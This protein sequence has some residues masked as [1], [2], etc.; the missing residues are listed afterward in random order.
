M[1][2][3]AESRAFPTSKVHL[4]F[5]RS[6]SKTSEDAVNTLKT[7]LRCR[8]SPAL[9]ATL[10]GDA[11]KDGYDECFTTLDLFA[12]DLT[13]GEASFIKCGA[14]DSYLLRN[15]EVKR[16][17]LPSLPLGLAYGT[18]AEKIGLWLRE[19]DVVVTVSDGIVEEES[20]ETR[21]SDLLS[22]IAHSPNSSPEEIADKILSNANAD[23]AKRK[24]DMTV[25]VIKIN[26]R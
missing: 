25:S 18:V 19:G 24:D 14:A 3:R 21:L 13:S 2:T 26:G 8:L 7:L 9:S 1:P 12:L 23:G 5:D 17:S 11:V 6:R 22:A 20:D 4:Y 16:L 10:T 15:G